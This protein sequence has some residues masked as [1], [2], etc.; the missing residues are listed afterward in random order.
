MAIKLPKCQHIPLSIHFQ[1]EG[2]TSNVVTF[3]LKT[4][5][6]TVGLILWK[7]F[8]GSVFTKTHPSDA[9][10]HVADAA[11]LTARV[12]LSRCRH[13]ALLPSEPMEKPPHNKGAMGR[14]VEGVA[15][16]GLL[17]QRNLLA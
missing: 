16:R 14:V 11:T 10:R 8:L 12:G 1:S 13:R 6:L 3:R 9:I 7:A 15:L 2:N 4:A 5:D 17:R